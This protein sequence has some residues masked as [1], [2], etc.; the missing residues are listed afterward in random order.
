MRKFIY[1]GGVKKNKKLFFQY[2]LTNA[3]NYFLGFL[4]KQNVKSFNGFIWIVYFGLTL[5]IYIIYKKRRDDYYFVAVEQH[6]SYKITRFFKN[7]QMP[8][9]KT[10][11]GLNFTRNIQGVIKK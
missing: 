1:T 10:K 11:K 4:E 5:Y 7:L 2:N 3:L 9:A 6:F 8:I